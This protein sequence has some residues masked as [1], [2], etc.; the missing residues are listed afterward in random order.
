MQTHTSLATLVSPRESGL[1]LRSVP[2]G[3]GGWIEGS[4]T[5][6]RQALVDRQFSPLTREE[7][8]EL[9]ASLAAM[10]PSLPPRKP[11]HANSLF[12]Y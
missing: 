7:W 9:R 2:A 5:R 3:S 10:R 8:S 11:P 12:H 4:M 6:V 1:S